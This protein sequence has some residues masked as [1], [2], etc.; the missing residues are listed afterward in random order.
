MFL[1]DWSCVSVIMRGVCAGLPTFPRRRRCGTDPHTYSVKPTRLC[2][3]KSLNEQTPAVL[4]MGTWLRSA[5]K[6]KCMPL[7]FYGLLCS[8]RWLS[9]L[10]G[11]WRTPQVEKV[12]KLSVGPY[13]W[14]QKCL[15]SVRRPVCTKFWDLLSLH[16]YRWFSEFFHI[17]VLWLT[18]T[19]VNMIISPGILLSR[20]SS[21]FQSSQWLSSGMSKLYK[22]I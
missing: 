16:M 17:L 22:Y 9:T 1:G 10:E 15:Y 13:L 20:D 2:H 8:N 18:I 7:S 4:Q 5:A 3:F 21:S 11:I 14:K 12:G 6:L 19:S